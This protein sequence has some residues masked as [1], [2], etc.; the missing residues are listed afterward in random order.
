MSIIRQTS[1]ELAA[2]REFAV[3]P[4][5]PALLEH[6]VVVKSPNWLGDAVM[7]LPALHALHMMLPEK[8]PLVVV[9][10]AQVADL[11]RLCSGV[12]Y[13]ITI[14]EAHKSWDKSVYAKLRAFNFK[15]GVMFSNS[16]RDAWQMRCAGI[17]QLYGRAARCR[18]LLMKKTFRFPAWQKGILNESHHANEYLS[19]VC[20]MG[21][22][23]PEPLMPQLNSKLTMGQLT[24]K[25]QSFCQHP[26][27]LLMAPGAAYGAAKRW[28]SGKFNQVAAA[29][30]ERGGIVAVLGSKSERMIGDEVIAGLPEN[31]AFNLS[32]ETNFS[33]LYN[34][35]KNARACVANDSGI[36]HLAAALGVP[37][38]A[39]FGP[40]DYRATGPVSDK[41]L[42]IYD[43]EKCSPCFKRV[44]PSGSRRCMEKLSADEVIAALH[45]L[46]VM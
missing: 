23:R 25:M 38:V 37:G 39:V 8:A 24:L 16:L 46:K 2:A 3:T 42:I 12:T 22:K 45:E 21:A 36:M 5:A 14:K 33:D 41:W 20:S 18:G 1:T 6:G 4:I 43:K 28:D 26:K 11:Y 30:I 29:Y 9:A 27:L 31:K 40:T 13:V 35:L 17:R 44:C 7:T 34:L 19:I 10:P 32:G 15:V